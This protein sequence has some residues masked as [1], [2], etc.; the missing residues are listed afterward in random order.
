MYS[1]KDINILNRT[2][3][4]SLLINIVSSL[5]AIYFLIDNIYNTCTI[6]VLLVI[7]FISSLIMIRT[8]YELTKLNDSKNKKIQN[9]DRKVNDK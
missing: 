2:S 1:M 7:S 9:K 5:S 3:I 4:I 8:N 6:F